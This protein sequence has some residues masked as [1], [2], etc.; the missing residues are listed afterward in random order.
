MVFPHFNFHF[1]LKYLVTIVL[2]FKL[3]VSRC[4]FS[5]QVDF[6]NGYDGFS[7]PFRMALRMILAVNEKL[8]LPP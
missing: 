1:F 2:I 4:P 8:I 3:P 6:F 5:S 7:C